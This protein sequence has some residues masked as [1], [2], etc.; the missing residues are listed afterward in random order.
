[1]VTQPSGMVTR[2]TLLVGGLAAGGAALAA[3]GLVADDVLPGRVRLSQALGLNGPGG[4]IP[5]VAGGAVVRGSFTSAARR[6][7]RTRWVI[8]YPPGVAP[9]GP[10]PV[11]VVLHGLNGDERSLLGLG[12]DRILADAVRRGVPPF[13]LASV[14]GGNGYWHARRNGDDAGRMVVEELLPMLA[15]HGLAAGSG[16]RVALLGWS[17]G[18]FGALLLAET[19][20]ARRVAAV[21]VMSAALWQRPGDTVEGAFDDR[22]DYLTHDVFAGRSALHGITV[23]IDCGRGDPFLAADRAFAAGLHPAPAG[24][25]GPGGHDDGYWRRVAPAQ[26][27]TLGTA[28]RSS[29]PTRS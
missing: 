22:E 25:F 21:G 19:L 16:D 8:A 10:L 28:L 11:C 3:A 6:G 4:E 14:A 20:G 2:R 15:G 27:A 24:G 7:I 26:L 5:D 13:A 23:R 12:L 1:M 17:M 18:G 29:P 9:G